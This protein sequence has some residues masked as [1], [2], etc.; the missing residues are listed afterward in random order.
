MD[1]A[2]EANTRYVLVMCVCA[3]E[4]ELSGTVLYQGRV[5]HPKHGLIHVLGYQNTARNLA[6]GPNAMLLHLPGKR[7]SQANFI[8]TSGCS[9]ILRDMVTAVR[10]RTRSMDR[11]DGPAGAGAGAQIEVFEHDIYTVVLADNPLAIPAAMERVPEDKRIHVGADLM[12]FYAERFPGYAVALCCFN[13]R[14]ARQ[15]NPLLLW[16]TPHDPDVL[17]L[18]AI[19][20]HT[21]GVPDLTALV[22]TDH[23]V[24]LG[25]DEAP[26]GWGSEVDYGVVP[27][28][29]DW[30]AAPR[31]PAVK[32]PAAGFLP[33]RVI[34][35]YFTGHLPNGDFVIPYE[36]VVRGDL[37]T[38]RR[39]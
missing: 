15:A 17:R 11:M 5:E 14:D 9:R 18:P 38:L 25:I 16:Y 7:M 32:G 13:N 21:G 36:D 24:I 27:V 10:P 35:R 8:D 28:V 26:D 4:A 12:A 3:A 37:T 34:G 2:A 1:A 6:S 39:A 20:C 22:Q 30:G 23:W 29:R 19:D 33:D 31:S